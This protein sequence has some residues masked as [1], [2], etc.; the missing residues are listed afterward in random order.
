[1]KKSLIAF[2]AFAAIAATTGAQA[3]DMYVG[4][5][6]PGLLTLGY[7]APINN[8]WG[9]HAELAG[10]LNA[11]LDGNRDGVDV[12][13]RLTSTTLGAFGDWF[14]ID[15]SGFRVVGGLTVNDVRA[16]LS[17]TGSGTA[18]INGTTVNMA[19]QYYNVNLTFPSV[20]PYIGIGYGHKN[21]AKGFGFYADIGMMVGTFD[22]SSST[23]LV[24]SG[25]VTQADVDAQN[26][27]LRD[28]VGKIGFLPSAS[29]GMTYRF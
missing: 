26:Q 8:N 11:S 6:L 18:V 2:A 7:A 25:Q 24:A 17:A 9:W 27:K 29:V 10:G 15:G 19:G 3:Q 22:V 14:P 21:P 13:G 16:N 12:T 20:T 1:M 28:G 4:V 23:S 5:G